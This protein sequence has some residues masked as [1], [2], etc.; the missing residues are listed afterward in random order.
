MDQ[1]E[2]EKE[3]R[4]IIKEKKLRKK[5]DTTMDN[6]SDSLDISLSSDEATNKTKRRRE[7]VGDNDFYEKHGHNKMENGTE[8]DLDIDLTSTIEPYLSPDDEKKC[9]F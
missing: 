7:M 8:T 4:K 2:G 5:K 3:R 9:I 6:R 1:S